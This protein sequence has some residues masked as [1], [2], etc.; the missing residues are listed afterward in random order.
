MF[1][2]TSIVTNSHFTRSSAAGMRVCTRI[3]VKTAIRATTVETLACLN[4]GIDTMVHNTKGKTM[5]IC[6]ETKFTSNAMNERLP[7][8]A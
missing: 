5:E 1:G 2:S 6:N 8:F 3:Q 7:A 4:G